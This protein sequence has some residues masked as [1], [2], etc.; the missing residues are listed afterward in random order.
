MKY[1]VLAVRGPGSVCGAAK[2]Y[3]SMDGQELRWA[4]IQGAKHYASHMNETT[5]S[6]NC[7]YFVE[8]ID[9]RDN[10]DHR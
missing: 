3:C 1:R 7:E 8:P 6:P 10:S 9:G 4:S 2:R 5:T